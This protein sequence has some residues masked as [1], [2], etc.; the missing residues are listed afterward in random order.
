MQV[1]GVNHINI[2]AGDLAATCE[3][4]EQLLGMHAQP[5]PV[6]PP[7]FDGCWITDAQGNPIVHVQAHN[8]ERHGELKRGL[9]GALDHV[10]L[11]CEG[12]ADTKARCEALGIEYRVNDRQFGDLRQVF[13][14][15][16]NGVSLELNYPGD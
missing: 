13:V 1:L 8:A 12:F 5:I 15:D 2:V 6:A 10:S 7:G 4:Y 16:P 14:L 11:T 3:F 9:N